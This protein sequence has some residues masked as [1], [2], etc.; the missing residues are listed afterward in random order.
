MSLNSILLILAYFLSDEEL[1]F[2]CERLFNEWK[3]TI[4]V[5]KKLFWVY[6]NY[7]RNDLRSY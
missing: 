7:N 2:R 5:F 1:L 6:W 4:I 3:E